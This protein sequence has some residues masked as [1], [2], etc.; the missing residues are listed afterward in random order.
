MEAI[1]WLPADH[2]Y[3][4]HR[5]TVVITQRGLRRSVKL[6]VRQESPC[7]WVLSARS[8][9]RGEQPQ[10]AVAEADSRRLTPPGG[11]VSTLHKARARRHAR[12]TGT[13]ATAQGPA[14]PRARPS[15]R[16]EREPGDA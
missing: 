14:A 8:R 15:V 1:V 7:P 10:R 16:R 13:G 5:L 9:P 4:E 3:P 2:W 12:Q 6:D 11:S